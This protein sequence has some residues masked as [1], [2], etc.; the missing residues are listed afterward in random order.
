VVLR[1]NLAP[2]GSVLKATGTTI[3]QHA[4]I[5]RVFESESAAYKAI[6]VGAIHS[7]DTV[8][9]RN[10]GPVGGPG[11][12][13]TARVTAAVVGLGLKDTVALITDGRFSG[14]THGLAVGHVSPEAAV[15]GPIAFVRDGDRISI[16]LHARQLILDVS[17]EELSVRREGWKPSAFEPSKSVFAKYARTVS[18]A[19][20][21]AVCTA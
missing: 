5:A 11:M 18:S 1:G 20:L 3:R 9:I 21:G 6:R 2:D 16:D 10:E 12:S 14:I 13:E 7:G 15:G 19:S 4:G 8:V 17:D